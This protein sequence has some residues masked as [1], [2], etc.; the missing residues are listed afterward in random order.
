MAVYAIGDVQGCYDNLCRLLDKINFDDASD[1]LWFCGDLVNRGPDSLATLR[2]VKEL[3]EQAVTVLGNHDLHLLAMHHGGQPVAES[4]TFYA[5]LNSPDC[6]ELLAWLQSRPLLHFDNNLKMLLVHAGIHP[7][8]SLQQAQ[9]Y[10]AEIEQT[11]NGPDSQAFFAQMYGDQ[12][13]HWHEGL[14]GMDRKRCITNILTRMRFFSTDERLDMKAKGGPGQHPELTPWYILNHRLDD[15][16]RIVFGHW[17]T[18]A[19][20][21]YGYHFAID[22][23]CVWGGKFVALQVDL[24]EPRWIS[25]S[26]DD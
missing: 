20:G 1:S 12:P 24:Q 11:L 9:H 17:S 7:Q 16:F 3:G 10:A 4:D 6:D 25:I 2:F 5:V 8:W 21:S 14:S 19:V 15:Q 23:G 26:C 18:L 13:S 22:G